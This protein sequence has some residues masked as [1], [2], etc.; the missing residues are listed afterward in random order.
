MS[1]VKTYHLE[2]VPT[3]VPVPDFVRAEG[4]LIVDTEGIEDSSAI[5]LAK[6]GTVSGTMYT[7]QSFAS[8]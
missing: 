6:D 7:P 3:V 2:Q 4:G 5:K 8:D 1:D